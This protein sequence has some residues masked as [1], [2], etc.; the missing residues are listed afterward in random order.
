[1]LG[2]GWGE[3]GSGKESR[4]GSAQPQ[5]AVRAALCVLRFVLCILRISIVVVPVPYVCCSVKLP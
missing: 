4:L 3:L 1:M 5:R 2:S